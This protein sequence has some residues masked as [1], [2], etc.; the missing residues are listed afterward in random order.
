MSTATETSTFDERALAALPPAPAFVEAI[1]TQAFSELLALPVPSQE[2]EEWRYTDLSRFD[3][4]FAPFAAGGDA[5]SL[6]RGKVL[7][8]AGVV[9]ERAGLQIQRNSEVVSRQLAPG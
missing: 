4:S 8:A 7:Q 5:E 3:L 6:N 2:T 9:G 1:R